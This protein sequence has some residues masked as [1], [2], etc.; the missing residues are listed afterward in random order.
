MARTAGSIPMPRDHK[1]PP[2][3]THPCVCDGAAKW[4]SPKKHTK[5][6]MLTLTTTDGRFRFEDP[7]FVTAKAIGRLNLVAQHLAAMPKEHDLPED[8]GQCAAA[9]ANY[10]LTHAPGA[11]AMVTVEVQEQEF[12]Y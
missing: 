1:W 9:L 10:I 11:Y 4:V 12:L 5:A 2:E 6:V 7:I 8:D 3:G